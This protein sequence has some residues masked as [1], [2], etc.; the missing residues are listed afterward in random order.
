MVASIVPKCSPMQS[1]D[2]K[3]SRTLPV[4]SNA[5]RLAIR[6]YRRNI[7]SIAWWIGASRR[8]QIGDRKTLV[9]IPA[10]PFGSF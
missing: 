9:H 1:A 10:L 5:L 6:F 8:G 4:L 7:L 2:F 3:S